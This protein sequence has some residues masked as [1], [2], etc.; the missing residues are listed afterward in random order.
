MTLTAIVLIDVDPP[1]TDSVYNSL[2]DLPSIK[3]ISSVYGIHDIFLL[4]EV[5]DEKELNE[6][7]FKTLRPTEGVRETLTLM[8]TRSVKKD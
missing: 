6:F 2:K 5:A 4:L 8:I 1:L 3:E 7:I